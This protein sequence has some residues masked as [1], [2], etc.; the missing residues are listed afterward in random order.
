MS[1]QPPQPPLSFSQLPPE[2]RLLLDKFYRSHRSHMRAATG[3]GIQRWV[4]RQPEIVAGLNLTP[5]EEGLWL[6]GLFVAP[7]RRGQGIA[8]Q[9]VH[10]ALASHP[11][12][13]WLFCEP[14]MKDFYEKLGFKPN[15]LLPRALHDRLK[16]YQQSKS[17]LALGHRSKHLT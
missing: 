11:G 6:T 7:H 8:R 1:L 17:L 16:R 15:P 10:A 12:S 2:H 14:S 4:A 3:I 13:V 9:L 5:F